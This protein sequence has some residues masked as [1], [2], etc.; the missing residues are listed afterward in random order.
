MHI[1]S[2]R[3]L[4]IGL[5]P[6]LFRYE[7]NRDA[8]ML[9]RVMFLAPRL[10]AA[11][12]FGMACGSSDDEAAE[13]DLQPGPGLPPST[14]VVPLPEFE[15]Q[16]E[17]LE[18]PNP[19]GFLEAELLGEGDPAIV[20]VNG[21][22]GLNSAFVERLHRG[23]AE[24]LPGR[25]I[26][27]YDQRGLGGSTP[28]TADQ[29]TIAG[30]VEDLESIRRFLGVEEFHLVGQSFGGFVSGAYA[31]THS[32]NVASIAFIDPTPPLPADSE[33]TTR[34][35]EEINAHYQA[36]L[37]AGILEEPKDD[38]S[39]EIA[40]NRR[41]RLLGRPS[42]RRDRVDCTSDG[43]QL[44]RRR[45]RVRRLP[46]ERGPAGR[47]RRPPE[48]PRFDHRRRQLG[49]RSGLCRWSGSGVRAG[50]AES[51]DHRGRRPHY[52]V[53]KPEETL[54]ALENFLTTTLAQPASP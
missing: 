40:W 31:A 37:D 23:M 44:C 6:S 7:R 41:R 54:G 18:I 5:P 30:A 47:E 50:R 35:N 33:F 32:Q 19:V 14:V 27:R 15:N 3:S 24:K 53:R 34:A 25:R 1:Q 10:A 43:E 20:I 52:L 49:I 51:L 22:P 4:A 12:A 39:P 29:N 16:T 17:T 2:E 48:A 21:G 38:D 36:L 9:R 45:G 13:A 26:V 28:T 11:F 46:D 42:R 8:E